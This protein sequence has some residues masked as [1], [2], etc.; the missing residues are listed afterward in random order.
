MPL[1]PNAAS[2]GTSS[3]QSSKAAITLVAKPKLFIIDACRPPELDHPSQYGAVSDP[4]RTPPRPGPPGQPVPLFDQLQVGDWHTPLAGTDGDRTTRFSDFCF[5]YSTVPY[6]SAGVHPRSGSNFLQPIA[7]RLRSDPH[8]SFRELLDVANGDMQARHVREGP[9]ARATY[10]Q[11]AQVYSTLNRSLR[12]VLPPAE[13]SG[14]AALDAIKDVLEASSAGIAMADTDAA[15]EF[16]QDRRELFLLMQRFAA[17]AQAASTR[18]TRGLDDDASRPE[19][20]DLSRL[21]AALLKVASK[22]CASESDTDMLSSVHEICSRLGKT[23]LSQLGGLS[24]VLTP[25][26]RGGLDELARLPQAAKPLIML[27]E[28]S[29]D[30]QMRM[31]EVTRTRDMSM[32]AMDAVEVGGGGSGGGSDVTGASDASVGLEGGWTS[33]RSGEKVLLELSSLHPGFCYLF[34]LN[35]RDQLS[36]VFPSKLDPNNEVVQ[37]NGLLHVPS[38]FREGVEKQYLAFTTK[39]HGTERETFYLLSTS[40]RL[41]ILIGISELPNDWSKLPSATSR[42][43]LAALERRMPASLSRT[44]DL[45]GSA[46]MQEA[47]GAEGSDAVMALTSL[48]LISEGGVT[49]GLLIDE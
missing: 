34:H 29:R 12:F 39:E 18:G 5:S 9:M 13:V 45:D 10:P 6:N 40:T 47:D 1:A 17:K 28:P 8:L 19:V 25:K 42:L 2:S 15:I 37:P 7:A 43:I 35:E 44:R 22:V 38:R 49:R 32:A 16:E 46:M 27:I 24:R 48:L 26:L 23:E 41:E 30:H 21:E 11:C 31:R 20:V 4:L 14:A 33:V 3:S 36:I